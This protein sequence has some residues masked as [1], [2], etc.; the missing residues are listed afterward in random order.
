[1]KNE[2]CEYKKIL[3]VIEKYYP[4]ECKFSEKRYQESKEYK[5]YKS[6]IDNL[7]ICEQKE[8]E[9]YDLLCSIFC[10]YYVKRWTNT[11]YP[12]FQFSVLLHKNQ[13]ILDDDIELMK[14]LNGRRLNLEIFIS[15]I[16]QYYYIYTSEEIY[17][18]NGDKTWTFHSYSEKYAVEETCLRQLQKSME[19]KGMIKLS[20]KMVHV[21][22]PFIET[23][24]LPRKQ[25][26]L[27]IFN[28]L[29]S[30]MEENYY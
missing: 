19:E 13:S 18:I 11:T 23:E 17:K 14:A 5:R 8:K 22:V 24:L 16:S 30:D 3:D 25:H 1:M 6:V 7:A 29:F 21:D 9:Y 26:D 28:C 12:S 20:K 27:E 15:R 4:T 2:W 10:E